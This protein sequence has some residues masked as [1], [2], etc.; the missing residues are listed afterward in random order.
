[1]N[2]YVMEHFNLTGGKA[3]LK[4]NIQVPVGER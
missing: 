1:M 3:P 4:S 2:F